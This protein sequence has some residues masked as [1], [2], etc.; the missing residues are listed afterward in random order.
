MMREP[1]L[2]CARRFPRILPSTLAFAA[3]LMAFGWPSGVTAQQASDQAAASGTTAVCS[4]PSTN[5]ARLQSALL[6]GPTEAL[7][8]G[9][10]T[11]RYCDED[12]CGCIANPYGTLIFSCSCSSIDCTRSCD[13]IDCHI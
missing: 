1:C 8:E 5:Q 2:R 11:C 13:N 7:V 10:I 9:V 4:S 6:P 12:Y 3:L